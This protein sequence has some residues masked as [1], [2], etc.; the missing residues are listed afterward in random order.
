M[1]SLLESR[2]CVL[3]LRT[4]L[5]LQRI[6]EKVSHTKTG[7]KSLSKT[8]WSRKALPMVLDTARPKYKENTLWHPVYRESQLA[9]GWSELKCKEW[10]DLAKED[11]TYKLAPEERRRYK[12][13]RYL[14]LNKASTNRPMK[15][16]S[17]IKRTNWTAHPSR[18]T[19]TNTTRTRSFLRRSPLQ[20]SSWPTYRMRT[21]AFICKFLV[22]V[23][24][25]MAL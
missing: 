15:L 17:R 18:T 5:D 22:V 13:Q 25:W 10:D 19:K 4:M 20:R 3:H 16:T 24:I 1:S 12:G 23:R 8:T 21:L 11:H 14:I 2:N 6:Q 9:I 7:C